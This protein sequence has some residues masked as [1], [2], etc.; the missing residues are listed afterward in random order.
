[1]VRSGIEPETS[2]TADWRLTNWDNQAAVSGLLLIFIFSV[3]VYSFSIIYKDQTFLLF[4]VFQG[5]FHISLRT[6]LSFFSYPKG[7]LSFNPSSNMLTFNFIIL[8]LG[9][10]EDQKISKRNTAGHFTIKK[11]KTKTLKMYD[12]AALVSTLENHI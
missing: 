2:R 11:N 7:H 4:G 10:S 3:A 12:N 8:F 5:S 1:M 9:S 6:S